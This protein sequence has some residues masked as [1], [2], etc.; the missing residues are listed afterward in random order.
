M[1]VSMKSLSEVER[2]CKD[3]E[4]IDASISEICQPKL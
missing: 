4:K 1:T 3:W 2:S